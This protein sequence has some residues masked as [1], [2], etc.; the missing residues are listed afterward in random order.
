MIVLKDPVIIAMRV[1]L[2]SNHFLLCLWV[3]VMSFIIKQ[4]TKKT[5]SF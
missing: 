5:K 4:E 1:G 2:S 3:S